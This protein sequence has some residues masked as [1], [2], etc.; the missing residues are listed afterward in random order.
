[1]N[2][3]RIN[4][5]VPLKGLQAFEA[6][7]RCGSVSAAALELKVSPGA[8]SQQIRKIE[9]FLGVTLLERNG[10]TVELTQWGRLYHQEISKGFEQFA[11]AEQILERARN[12]N[13][14]VLSALSSVVNKWIGRRIFDWQALHPNAHVRIVGR[15]KEPRMGFDDIDFRISYGSD[16]LQHEHY[17]ELFR[18]WVVPA[19]SPALIKGKAP[20]AT[21]LLQYPLLHVEWERHFT[22]Y[23]SWLEFAAKT[24]A[25][26]EE[27]AADLS[28]TLS[29]SAIDAAV[30]KRGVV[31][32]QMS[33]IADELE[34]QTLIIPLDIRIPLRESYFLAWDRAALEKP[35]GRQ[36][37]D[38]LV[39]IS[40][41]QG[42]VSAPAP[43]F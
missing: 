6:V 40:R 24:G 25:A 38:W 22:P 9:S 12:E 26:L 23:P 27:T 4:R 41:Q 11:A 29:S 36:F 42:L 28:F 7:G 34:A 14:L 16:V 20:S 13:A 33:M 43:T 10:R 2:D 32:A 15:D 8:V 19:C 18:D 37:R 39:A 35:H 31:L 3:K 17:T 5:A 21:Q 30:N 1:M